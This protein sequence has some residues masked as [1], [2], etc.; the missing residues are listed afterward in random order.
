MILDTLY[1]IHS[2]VHI[3]QI[4]IFKVKRYM[5]TFYRNIAEKDGV[6][7]VSIAGVPTATRPGHVAMTAGF[8]E[9][10]TSVAK[11]KVRSN[12]IR[13]NVNN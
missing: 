1:I 9:D 13:E 2:R 11:G 7:G 10:P 5:Y 6:W 8:Y 4:V 3:F 12:I